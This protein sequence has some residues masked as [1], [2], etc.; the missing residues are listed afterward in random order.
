[1]PKS[2]TGD[3]R[4]NAL[5]LCDEIGVQKASEQTGIALNSLYGWR[6]ARGKA[7]AVVAG[8]ETPA[9]GKGRGGCERGREDVEES[10][11]T[12]LI[13]LQMENEALKA[14]VKTLQNALRAFTE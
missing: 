5:K 13:R 3:E 2:Y 12:E 10:C 14:Q 7:V 8:V 1:M 11:D 6:R 4:E 9:A